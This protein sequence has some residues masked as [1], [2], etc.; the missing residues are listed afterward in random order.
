MEPALLPPGTLLMSS[1]DTYT[2]RLDALVAGG[3]GLENP[4]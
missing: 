2:A 4:S 1:L 3:R